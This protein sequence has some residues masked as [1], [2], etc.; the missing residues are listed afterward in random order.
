MDVTAFASGLSGPEG[1]LL[2]PDGDWLIVE[3]G[4]GRGCVTRISA[5]GADVQPLAR[6]GRP[7][8]LARDRAGTVWVAES[9][10]NPSLL[11]MQLDG[12]WEIYATASDDGQGFLFPNDL[13]F[14]PEGTLYLTDSG[15][16]LDDW[17]P[18]GNLK[19]NWRVLSIDTGARRVASV[20]TGLQFP[21]GIAFGADG[22]LYV[23]EM[24]G[25]AVYRYRVDGLGAV[26]ERE[27]FGNVNDPSLTEGYGPAGFR[28]PDGMK[29]GADGHLYVTVFGQQDVTV[30][31]LKGEVA[32]RIKTE[33]RFP[34]NLAFGPAGSNRIYVT[35]GELGRIEVL[36][37]LT[38]GARLYE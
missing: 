19:S 37:V 15:I 28:G 14:G 1:P 4:S 11:T 22:Y 38:D 7:N 25:G 23:N 36:N 13:C 35:E 24:I 27:E 34:T 31:G 17:A 20:D 16:Y 33:G 26:G 5:D 10:P 3:M 21:N 30:L 2:L 29:F 12:S 9:Y 32:Q 18:G 6:T 8:G